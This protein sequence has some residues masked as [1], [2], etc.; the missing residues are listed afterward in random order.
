MLV[1]AGLADLLAVKQEKAAHQYPKLGTGVQ[2][3]TWLLTR[4]LTIMK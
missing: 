3:I 2:N 1:S 4:K